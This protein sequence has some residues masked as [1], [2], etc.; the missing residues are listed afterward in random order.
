MTIVYIGTYTRSEPHV[1]GQAQGIYVYELDLATGALR[2]LSTA[3]GVVNPSFVTLDSQRRFLYAV[4]EVDAHAG[5]PGGA[6]SAFAIDPHTGALSP[7]N[8]QHT[9]GRH[10][11][12]V[13]IDPSGRWLLVANYGGGSVSVLPIGADG[14]LGPAAAVVQ[15]EGASTHHDGPH[16]H[17]IVPDRAGECVLVPDCGLDRIM[18]YRLDAQQGALTPNDPP[19][20]TLRA[21]SG[22]RHLAFS[23]DGSRLY[24]INERGSSVTAFDYEPAQGAL[25]EIQT[26]STLPDGFAGKNSCADIHLHPS[27]RFLYGSNRGHNSIASFAVH[28]T[29]GELQPTGHTPTGGRTPRNFAIDPSGTLLLAANQDSGTIV[30]FRIDQS[31][32]AL[33]PTGQVVQVPTPVCVCFA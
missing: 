8:H 21:G 9:H 26:V 24:C 13:N 22:P 23:Q 30:I 18:L 15:H 4:Q 27:G 3:P 7:I 29:S 28:A 25:R 20:G 12:Y 2:H 6:A 31:T 32:G 19:W 17:A 16:P 33:S 5:Q 14:A 11:C 1:Q 10:P